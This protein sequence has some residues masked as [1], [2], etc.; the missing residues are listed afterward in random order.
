MTNASDFNRASLL[1][2]EGVYQEFYKGDFGGHVFRGNQHSVGGVGHFDPTKATLMTICASGHQNTIA[3]PE[4][5]IERDN[6]GRPTGQ[7]S[8]GNQTRTCVTCSK[9]LANRWKLVNG[10]NFIQ[11]PVSSK[12]SVN[13]WLF[14][15]V[16]NYVK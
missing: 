8:A 14:G 2:P 7:F 10:Q 1:G 6:Q 9:P 11:P 3:I 12:G 5:W 13:A 4:Q 16:K 15:G